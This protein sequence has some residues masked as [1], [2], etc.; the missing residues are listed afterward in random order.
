MSGTLIPERNKIVGEIGQRLTLE[1]T[2]INR[3]TYTRPSYVNRKNSQVV[4]I[5]VMVTPDRAR[6]V[7]KSSRFDANEGDRFRIKATVKEHD[8]FQGQAQTIVQRLRIV[9]TIVKNPTVIK[10]RMAS[11]RQAAFPWMRRLG[12]G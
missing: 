6:I 10:N 8:Q 4:Y 12:V 5:V 11:Y 1:V 7:S 3:H 9:E 2:V